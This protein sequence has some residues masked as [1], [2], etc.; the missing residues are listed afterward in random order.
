MFAA[1]QIRDDVITDCVRQSLW[2]QQ[3]AHS[4][5]SFTRKMGDEICVLRSDGRCGNLRSVVRISQGARMRQTIVR[6]ASGSIER[7]NGSQASCGTGSYAAIDH[8][9][10]ISLALESVFRQALIEFRIEEHDFPRDTT[11]TE[12]FQIV[13]VVNDHN[14]SD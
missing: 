11:T 5:F 6:A 12:G 14:L 3:Q 9:L 10:P 13:K 7:R 2:G 8:C 1:L 4:Y